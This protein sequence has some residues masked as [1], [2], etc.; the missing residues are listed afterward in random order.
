[1]IVNQTMDQERALY[2]VTDALVKNCI[3]A[4][5]ADGES[6]LKE[7]HQVDVEDCRF[8]LRYPLW[9]TTDFSMS[10]CEST[11]TARAA[12]W[13]AERGV[14]RD[15]VLGGVKALRECRQIQLDNCR[16]Q[17]TEFGWNCTDVTVKGGSLESEYVFMGSRNVTIHNWQFKGKY[18][19][20]Y[21]EN[22]TIE[23]SYLDTKD[24]FWHCRNVTVRNSVVKG[25]YLAWY[26][27]NLRL[28]NCRIIGTQPFCYC[29]NLVLVNCT[30]EDADLAF[31]CS[32]VDADVHGRILSIKNP[33]AGTI[34]VDEVDE[35]IIE[36]PV[37]P[38]ECRVILR[39]AKEA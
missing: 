4:G 1:M 12:L 11:D 6:A 7:C 29:K 33:M 17:S 38:T 32:E 39:E 5:E 27:E 2:H 24:A 19:F 22:L 28:E 34:V 31:E 36:N 20:Q 15:C 10:R 13:Y 14:I 9:H 8:L 16:I 35:I 26:S 21:V 3:F 37:R 23:D 18:S 30:M 25:E